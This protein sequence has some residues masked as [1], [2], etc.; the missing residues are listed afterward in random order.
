MHLVFATSL[1][2]VVEPRSGYD[3]ANRVIVDALRSMGHRVSVI[4]FLQP[5]AEMAERGDTMLL[6][7][8]EVTN[9]KVGTAQ[10]LRWLA[11]ALRRSEPVSVAK[12]HAASRSQVRQALASVEPFDGIVLNSVQLPGAFLDIFSPSPCLYVAHNVEAASAAQNAA[13]ADSA[14]SRYLFAREAR[15]LCEIETKLCDLADYVFTLADADRAALGVAGPEES[16]VLPLVTSIEPP[17]PPASR[18]PVFD[19][20]L[21]GSWTWAANRTGLDWFLEKIVPRLPAD[22]KIAVAGGLDDKPAGMPSNV[23]FLGRVPDAREFIRSVR[24]VPL[25]SRAG[26]GVQLKSI[27]TFELGL[28]AVAT[29]SSVRGIAERPTNCRVADDEAGFAAALIDLVGRMRAGENLD[30]D[31]RAFHKSQLSGLTTA[32]ATGIDRLSHG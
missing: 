18:A 11:S 26:T 14:V 2:P 12:M 28:P 5:G 1:I 31:G 6:G 23:E 15:L 3:I 21:I 17:A 10:K 30:V 4:G 27:E 25:V 32:L 9:A 16:G 29:E 13:G 20:G 7:E 24:V 19:V 22:F 8:L